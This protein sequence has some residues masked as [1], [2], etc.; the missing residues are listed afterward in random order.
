M[1]ARSLF[2]T[3]DM[4]EQHDVLNPVDQGGNT[5]TLG[6]NLSTITATNL[7]R[8]HALVESGRARGKIVFFL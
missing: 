1:F 7:K 5:T 8:A 6:E 4:I 2:R 3:P